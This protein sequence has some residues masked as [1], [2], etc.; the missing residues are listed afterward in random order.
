MH[1]QQLIR[2]TFCCKY[3]TTNKLCNMKRIT[4]LIAISFC[5]IGCYSQS[6]SSELILG[7]WYNNGDKSLNIDIN[8]SL[9]FSKESND[10]LCLVWAFDKSGDYT[11]R[12]SMLTPDSNK[13]IIKYKSK[14]A[15]WIFNE[16]GDLI[17]REVSGDKTY[18][19]STLNN[20]KLCVK[21]IS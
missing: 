13:D 16:K 11:V 5:I 3:K 15:K 21:R 6:K 14:P 10:T 2:H 4:F 9:T 1:N 20:E 12:L 17:I 19:V 7:D 8:E 18:K